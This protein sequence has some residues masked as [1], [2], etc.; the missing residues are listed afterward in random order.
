VAYYVYILQSEIDKTYYK[1]FT[2]NPIKRLF[3]HNAGEMNYTSRKTPWILVGLYE[4]E[5]K[6]EALIAEKKLKKY[7]HSR[8]KSF[9][10]SGKN[11][12]KFYFKNLG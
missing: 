12:L 7:D 8:I 6:K 10:N 11:I 1:G 5:T 9:V 2:E 4:F 3:Q